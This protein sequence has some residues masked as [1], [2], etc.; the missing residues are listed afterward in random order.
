MF[1]KPIST[2]G[3]FCLSALILI[4]FILECFAVTSSWKLVILDS[5][6]KLTTSG[7]GSTTTTKLPESKLYLQPNTGVCSVANAVSSGPGDCVL[8]TDTAFWATWDVSANTGAS[9]STAASSTFPKLFSISIASIFFSLFALL[10]VVFHYFKPASMSRFVMQCLAT[11]CQLLVAVFMIYV[12]TAADTNVISSADNWK[13]FYQSKSI[14][15]GTANSY[16]YIGSGCALI[17]FFCAVLSLV[18]TMFPT[19]CGFCFYCV[20]ESSGGKSSGNSDKP[21]LASHD[22]NQSNYV[23]PVV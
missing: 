20:D 9:A 2:L 12:T 15:C 14:T 23:P 8:F 6:V 16:M 13:N 18:L 11:V 7:S 4:S 1:F 5:C 22:D 21:G 17:S 10:I 19:L 3:L